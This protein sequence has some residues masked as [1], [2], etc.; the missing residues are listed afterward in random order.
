MGSISNKR[1]KKTLKQSPHK[2]GLSPFI[3]YIYVLCVLYKACFYFR[4]LYIIHI[5]Y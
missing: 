3:Y 1:E 5:I 4:Y 2:I